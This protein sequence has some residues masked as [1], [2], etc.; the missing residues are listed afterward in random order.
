MLDASALMLS[1]I[2][3]ENVRAAVDYTLE[4]GV[5]SQG[6]S[7]KA[8]AVYEYNG[9]F[10]TGNRPPLTC[11]SWEQESRGYNNLCGDVDLVEKSW[12]SVDAMPYNFVWTTLLW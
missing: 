9:D 3:P 6:H 2:K 4:H 5:Y 12:K 11:R 10:K 8:K 1:D 7:G